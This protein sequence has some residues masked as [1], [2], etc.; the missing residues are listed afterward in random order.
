MLMERHPR[1]RATTR[2]VRR[3]GDA[4]LEPGGG[5][6]PD[7]DSLHRLCDRMDH[8]G[9]IRAVTADLVLVGEQLAGMVALKEQMADRLDRVVLRAD[10]D[11][12]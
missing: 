11:A 7:D 4:P 10:R 2:A 3:Y 12:R 5:M 6:V 8:V 9:E 1:G